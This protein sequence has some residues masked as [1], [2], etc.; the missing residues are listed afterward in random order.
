MLGAIDAA[1][2]HA[3]YASAM[4]ISLLYLA[5]GPRPKDYIAFGDSQEGSL[6]VHLCGV[7]SIRELTT[8]DVDVQIGQN[9]M[10]RGTDVHPDQAVEPS[11]ADGSTSYRAYLRYLRA[12]A[13]NSTDSN[14][15]AIYLAAL[16]SLEIFCAAASDNDDEDWKSKADSD[17]HSKTPFAWQYRL[18]DSFI[19]RL[20]RRTPLA[21]AIFACWATV[22]GKLETGWVTEGWPEHIVFGI[23]SIVSAEDRLMIRWSMAQI[24]LKEPALGDTPASSFPE[25]RI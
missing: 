18:S 19:D 8:A 24:G 12:Q 20:Q 7:R 2:Y 5:L 1:S 25:D 15:A 23:W 3:A 11:A 16:D 13:A 6:L 10:N 17:P 22:L 14:S 4:L 9:G 21:L